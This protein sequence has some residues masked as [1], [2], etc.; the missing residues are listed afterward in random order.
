MMK[1]KDA[2]SKQ[3]SKHQQTTNVTKGALGTMRSTASAQ[4]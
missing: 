1:R 4:F 2:R 3:Q